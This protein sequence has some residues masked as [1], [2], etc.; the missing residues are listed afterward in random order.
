[1]E[2]AIVAE[3][4]TYAVG[5]KTIVDSVS[6]EVSPGEMVAIVGP[7][8]AGKSSLVGLLAG[9]LKPRSGIASIAGQPVGATSSSEMARLRTVMPQRTSVSFPFTAF[10]VVMMGRHPH[11]NGWR[12]SSAQDR[13]VVEEAMEETGVIELRDRIYSTLSG[14]E[15][16]RVALARAF[17]QGTGVLLLDEPTSALDIGHQELVMTRCRERADSG[18]AVLTV[19]H[20]L[21]VAASYADRVAV[22]K[23]GVVVAFDT[24]QQVYDETALADVFD[25]PV[26]VFG[27]PCTGCPVVLPD[28]TRREGPQ[29]AGMESRDPVGIG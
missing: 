15:Q 17:A 28:S 13:Q 21:N 29:S 14:G 19:L 4:L 18:L 8:G 10:E 22:M 27:H 23:D 2:A 20:E 16:R 12:V 9:D 5:S 6:L 7:N 11:Q 24:P 3:S 1:M 25:H 26:V